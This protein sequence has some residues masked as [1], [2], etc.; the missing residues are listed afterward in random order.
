MRRL[1]ALALTA[2]K[3][4][5]NG[6]AL[7]ESVAGVVIAESWEDAKERGLMAAKGYWESRD[8][9]YDHTAAAA[10]VSDEMVRNAY[11]LL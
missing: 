10:E 4:V 5:N 9:W 8:G 6:A 3:R 1:Y 7:S 11:A 2:Y